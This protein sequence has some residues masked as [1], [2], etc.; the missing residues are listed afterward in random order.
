MLETLF[1]SHI[2]FHFKI[3]HEIRVCFVGKVPPLW[4]VGHLLKMEDVRSVCHTYT[5]NPR[6]HHSGLGHQGNPAKVPPPPPVILG[7]VTDTKQG[8]S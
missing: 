7:G 6:L 3:I 4:K 2:I 5:C 8:I 1:S